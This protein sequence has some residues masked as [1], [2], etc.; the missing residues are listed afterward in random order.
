MMRKRIKLGSAFVVALALMFSVLSSTEILAART[1]A[2]TADHSMII[3]LPKYTPDE[4]SSADVTADIYKVA[5]VGVTGKYTAEEAFADLADAFT[6]LT[7][8]DNAAQW[9]AI[10]EAAVA[11]VEGGGAEPLLDDEEFTGLELT[12]DGLMPGLYLIMIP[13]ETSELNKYN[14]TPALVSLP[15]ID[16]D[17]EWV[18]SVEVTLKSEMLPREGFLIIEKE[19]LDYNTTNDSAVFV[20]EVEAEFEDEIIYNDVV[21]IDFADL[22]FAPASDWVKIGPM[23]AGAV[24]TVTEVYTG[25]SYE[26]VGQVTTEVTI[27]ADPALD[28]VEEDEKAAVIEARL[29]EMDEEADVI[30]T[31]EN[32]HND[33]PNGG[34]GIVNRFEATENGWHLERDDQGQDTRPQA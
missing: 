20:F 30:V 3:N 15:G 1:V 26:N 13:Q 24:A 4:L 5:A 2:Q 18:K 11:V 7:P 25:A 28:D 10:N 32:A 31:F 14:F 21:A 16:E 9:T 22:A 29:A 19:L 6:S 34:T 17:K 33:V 8:T 27:V 12:V 23:R